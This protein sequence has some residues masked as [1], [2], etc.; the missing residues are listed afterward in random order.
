MVQAPPRAVTTDHCHARYCP[1]ES[2]LVKPVCHTVLLSE[3][4]A[5]QLAAVPAAPRLTL[6]ACACAANYFTD[7]PPARACYAVKTLPLNAVVEIEAIALA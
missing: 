6:A 2:V 4:F 7:K 5:A 1:D 3:S